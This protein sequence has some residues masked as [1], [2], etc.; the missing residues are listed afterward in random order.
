MHKKQKCVSY[1]LCD[2]ANVSTRALYLT[3]GGVVGTV[4][5]EGKAH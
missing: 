3:L 1:S 5:I 4:M 2:Y